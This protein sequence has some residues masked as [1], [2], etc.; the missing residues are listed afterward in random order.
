MF[1]LIFHLSME[2]LTDSDLIDHRGSQITLTIG[3]V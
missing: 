2:G 1:V 3:Y